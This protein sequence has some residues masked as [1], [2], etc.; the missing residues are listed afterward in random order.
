[1]TFCNLNHNKQEF[2]SQL[3]KAKS[4]PAA[5][6]LFPHVK[7]GLIGSDDLASHMAADCT[8]S[9]PGLSD[10]AA[11]I[12]GGLDFFIIHASLDLPHEW[13]RPLLNVRAY[14]EIVL[15]CQAR[16]IPVG[17]YFDGGPSYLDLFGEMVAGGVPVFVT[18]PAAQEALSLRNMGHCRLV[19]P[20][21]SA[22]IVNPFQE[23]VVRELRKDVGFLVPEWA[24]LATVLSDDD[25]Q[26]LASL[27]HVQVFDD[28]ISRKPTKYP[29]PDGANEMLLGSLDA[30]ASAALYRHGYAA[31]ILANDVAPHVQ[32]ANLHKAMGYGVPVITTFSPAWVGNDLPCLYAKD[33][34]EAVDIGRQLRGNSLLRD[35][36]AN[37]SFKAFH[38][39]LCAPHGI[40]MLHE[41]LTGR[42]LHLPCP[43]ISC[44][45]PT[46]RLQQLEP[47]LRTFDSF[48]YE[49][50]ELLIAVNNDA[51]PLDAWLAPLGARKDVRV[52]RVPQCEP[53][54]RVMNIAMEAVDGEYVAKIDDD[55]IYG[56]EYLSDYVY[57]LRSVRFDL[58][59][60]VPAFWYEESGGGLLMKREFWKHNVLNDRLS[61]A[62]FLYRNDGRVRFDETVRGYADNEIQDRLTAEGRLLLSVGC[63][64]F[65]HVRRAFEH[66]TWR[67]S[68][69]DIRRSTYLVAENRGWLPAL[70]D[71]WRH[72]MDGE[73]QE[74]RQH[75][76][77]ELSLPARQYFYFLENLFPLEQSQ[78]ARRIPMRAHR[79]LRFVLLLM[80]L[81]ER[82]YGNLKR[83]LQQKANAGG[84]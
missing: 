10:M 60:K 47:S 4:L 77:V 36:L 78:E 39:K 69:D 55:D 46:M 76:V 35:A 6:P 32:L 18:T 67:L 79:L 19:P 49:N 5:E 73:E 72:V 62:T 9:R 65:V 20:L 68:S 38:A 43:K 59:G 11:G 84:H 22:K 57:A 1:M 40:A 30:A 7:V 8:V 61:G 74:L 58:A 15:A 3:A 52:M 14:R 81:L 56:P 37:L 13:R 34:K 42:A 31:V 50:K 82:G 64:D 21:L 25:W 27:E 44:L 29:L 80:V 53:M 75:A 48:Q 28:R 17:V 12:E 16:G 45:L 70:T 41:A 51:V 83:R 66:H 26:Q 63:F 54:G 24:T 33:L 71:S 2:V 23:T